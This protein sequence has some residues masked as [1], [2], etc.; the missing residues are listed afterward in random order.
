MK[1]SVS[2]AYHIFDERT[3]TQGMQTASFFTKTKFLIKHLMEGVQMAV[4][5]EIKFEYKKKRTDT[6]NVYEFGLSGFD[7]KARNAKLDKRVTTY[8]H[9]SIDIRFESTSKFGQ[10]QT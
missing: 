2:P 5:K 4:L 9:T 8:K 3:K 1:H 10:E 6:Q 7:W